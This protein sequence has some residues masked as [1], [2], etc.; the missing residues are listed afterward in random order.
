MNADLVVRNGMVMDGTGNPGI[1]AD[2]AM[3]DGRI[4]AIGSDLH[5]D[6]VLDASG[7]VVAPG[8]IDIHTHYDAQVFW[9]PAMTPSS[10]HGVTTVVLGNCGFTLAPTRPEHHTL[11]ARTLEQVEDMDF[12]MLQSGI[13]WD[14]VTFPEYLESV[15][16]HGC[17]LN[18]AAYIGHTAVRLFVMGDAAYER[19]ATPTELESMQAVVRD[20]LQAG[21]AGFS[22]S[23]G[24][25]HRGADGKP[26]PSRF[27][28]PAEFEALANVVAE[29]R[30]GVVGLTAGDEWDLDTVYELQHRLGIPFTWAALMAH[31][32]GWHDRMLEKNDE[33]WARGGAVWPQVSPRPLAFSV[34]MHSP[35]LLN[36]NPVF[37]ELIG[38]SLDARRSAYA[39]PDWRVRAEDAFVDSMPQRWDTF[40]IGESNS[41]PEA[42]DRRL[43]ELNQGEDRHPIHT[44]LDLAL[45]ESDLGLRVR[46]VL[47]NDYRPGVELLLQQDNCTLGLSDAGAHTGQICDAVQTTD[48]LALVRDRELMPLEKAVRKMS[49]VQADIFGFADRGYL[50]PGMAG[51]IV[52]FDPATVGPGPVR[53]ATDFPGDTARLTADEPT[54]MRHIIVNAVPI[55]VSGEHQEAEI[56]SRPG[57]FVRPAARTAHG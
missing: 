48:F 29:T 15:A 17:A 51:D 30:R 40:V 18:Y 42:V 11:L 8:F 13:P 43:L 52:V 4:V 47:A 33:W 19:H 28:N 16:R 31:E 23:A 53:R 54:G 41:H 12:A 57:Q 24:T 36:S 37:A 22:T 44:L 5:G 34:A 45:D 1:A 2:V 20:G 6:T 49:G 21:A 35:Y 3:S 27:A 39:D 56:A 32:S 38:K 25:L 50:R 10:F 46:I 14:F 26:I 7:A 9:D 55:R